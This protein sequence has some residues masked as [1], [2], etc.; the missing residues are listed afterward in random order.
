VS[1]EIRH[2]VESWLAANWAED[3][4]VR[5][6]WRRLAEARL[7]APSWPAPWGRGLTTG[8]SRVVTGVLAGAG[9]IAPPIGNVGLRLAGPTLLAHADARQLAGYLPPLLRGEEAWCQLFSEPGAGSDLP[10]LSARAVKDGYDWI[11]N[12][13]KVW[14][15]GAE[16]SRR[17][18]LLARTDPDAPKRDGISYFVLDMEQPGVLA[19]P[20]RM[21]NGA[22]DF[23]EVFLT[24]ARVHDEDMIGDVNRG[25]HVARTT[26]AL[27]RTTAADG[28]ARGLV[29][30]PSGEEAGQLDRTVGEVLAGWSSTHARF[31]SM[32]VRT[33]KMIDLAREHAAAG[34]P[35]V[36]Q[37]L[38]RY[39]SLTEVHRVTQGRTAA[40][41][42][43]G[44]SGPE[45]ALSKLALGRI[46]NTSRDLSFSILGAQAMLADDDAPEGGELQT[47]G[48][49]SPGVTIGAGTDEIQRN[50]IGERALGLPR[51]PDADIDPRARP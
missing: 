8:E 1:G 37:G 18:M 2:E 38:A 17:G 49:A 9:V 12:G 35:H 34:D 22:I 31:R 33:R 13:Q 15:S 48:L 26:L 29:P 6:W 11:V 14:N 24:D 19:R 51:E 4:T 3:I 36:R 20:L 7:V 41:A 30:V 46:C 43:S 28:G 50:T 32:A 45:G 27:E 16:V 39:S 23:C 5:E 47:I 25:W 10:S 44:R 42:G 21:M 40:A